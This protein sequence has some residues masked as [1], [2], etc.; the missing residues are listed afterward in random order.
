MNFCAVLR[1]YPKDSPGGAEYQAYLICRELVRR[2][3]DAQYLAHQSGRTETTVDDGITVHRL[4]SRRHGDVLSLI[5]ELDADVYYFRIA[6]DLPLLWRAKRRT[7]AAFVY[8]VSRDVQCQ[9]LFASGPTSD[10]VLSRMLSRG[11]YALYR[12]LLRAPDAVF[13]QSQQQQRLLRANHSIESTLVGNGHPIPTADPQE[14]SPPV[15]LWLAS[16]KRIKRPKQFLELVELTD[17]LACQFWIVGRPAERAVHNL[18]ETKAAEHDRLL[19]LGGCGILES[20]EYF[21]A[22][23]VFVHT[24]DAEGFPNT[25]IQSWLHK[26][27]VISLCTD[28]DNAI[29]DNKIGAHCQS[30]SAAAEALRSYIDDPAR[31]TEVGQNAYEYAKREHSISTIVDRV[32]QRLGEILNEN[33]VEQ[34][35]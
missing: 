10:S 8:N 14:E 18:V 21:D 15:V 17:D 3:H 27:P 5:D 9:P 4:D 16:L 6:H 23:S 13:A 26:T 12:S 24:G 33:D 22:A 31:R 11:R 20:N 32:E 29:S 30:V 19:Y 7:D 34:P 28:P 35:R 1:Q 2:G 25:F